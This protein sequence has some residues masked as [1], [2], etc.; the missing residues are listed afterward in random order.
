MDMN[1]P[2]AYIKTLL[3]IRKATARMN[4]PLLCLLQTGSQVSRVGSSFDPGLA[5]DQS[6]SAVD[7]DVDTVDSDVLND[8]LDGGGDL[9]GGEG[10]TRERGVLKQVVG[11]VGGEVGSHRGDDD[12]LGQH[13]D[14]K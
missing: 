7:G 9:V 3:W 2:N 4:C 14:A 6:P 8:V 10:N 1:T 11:E 5:A 13:R 12:G